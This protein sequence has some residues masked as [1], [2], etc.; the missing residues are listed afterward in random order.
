M[1]VDRW[2]RAQ[3][4]GATQ[5]YLLDVTFAGRTWRFAQSELQ[6]SDATAGITYAY[7]DVL[8]GSVTYRQAWDFLSQSPEPNTASFEIAWPESVAAL[9]AAGHDLGVVDL[10]L[11]LRIARQRAV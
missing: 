4:V 1:P 7:Q 6:V 11:D 3:L 5:H 10:H 2:N 8:V 9:I